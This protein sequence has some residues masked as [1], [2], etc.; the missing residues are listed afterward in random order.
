MMTRRFSIAVIMAGLAMP[1]WAGG[2]PQDISGTYQAQGRN[3]D[4][5]TY[6]GHVSVRQGAGGG[7]AF[8]WVVG[9]QS[10]AGTGTRE[11][12][13]VSVNWGDKFPVIYVIMPNGAL[14]GTWANGR[15]LERLQK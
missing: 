5:S 1:V 14:H 13:V 6:R 11:G 12:R 10:Y 4:G 8:A 3:P 15:A 2:I 7:V 9:K